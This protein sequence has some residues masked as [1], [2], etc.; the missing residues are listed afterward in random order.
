MCIRVEENIWNADNRKT[1][2]NRKIKLL[3]AL[4]TRDEIISGGTI[5]PHKTIAEAIC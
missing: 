3:V 5:A 2:S 1:S 4:T